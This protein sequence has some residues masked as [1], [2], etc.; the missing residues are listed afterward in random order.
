[1]LQTHYEVEIDLSYHSFILNAFLLLVNGNDIFLPLINCFT[2]ISI[3]YFM[4]LIKSWD[5]SNLENDI[6]ETTL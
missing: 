3:D 2:G 6:N 1:M 5:A 4:Y